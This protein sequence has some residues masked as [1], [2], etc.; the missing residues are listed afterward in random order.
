ME[1]ETLFEYALQ[2]VN[3]ENIIAKTILGKYEVWRKIKDFPNYSASSFGN[4]RNDK[5]KRI[6]TPCIAS[7]GYMC[8]TMRANNKNTYGLVHRL[9]ATTFCFNL[10]AKDKVDHINN[11]RTNNHINNLRWATISEN[12][13][14]KKMKRTNTSGYTGAFKD[15]WGY[16]AR[17]KIDGKNIHL[18]R[19]DT[20]EEASEAY[21]AKAKELYGEFYNDSD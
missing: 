8:V 10:N 2:L 9:I 21:K 18:G 15:K 13:H 5:T 7:N 20:V 17:I 14:N 6:L 11:D 12:N 4:L 16:R 3:D 19:F 1:A